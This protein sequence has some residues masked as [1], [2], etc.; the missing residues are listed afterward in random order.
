MSKIADK[1][2]EVMCTHTKQYKLVLETTP[3]MVLYRCV[4]CN[5]VEAQED[6][7]AAFEEVI[8]LQIAAARKE[9]YKTPQDI[10]QNALDSVA[11]IERVVISIKGKDDTLYTGYSDGSML[12]AVALCETAKINI[13]N[14]MTE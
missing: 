1:L 7:E 2:L 14:D 10:L 4:K 8:N 3:P 12:E 11:D 9:G 13:M 6:Y 5:R